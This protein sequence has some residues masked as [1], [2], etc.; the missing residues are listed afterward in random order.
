M[1]R[2]FPLNV[3]IIVSSKIS[4]VIVGSYNHFSNALRDRTI[5]KN[6]G[7]LRG[8][9]IFQV[10]RDRQEGMPAAPQTP[11]S[12]AATSYSN[13]G[14]SLPWWQKEAWLTLQ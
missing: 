12:K 2:I 14:Q 9:F 3:K 7:I 8:N 5:D 6:L 4:T 10:D 13:S 11:A 1:V